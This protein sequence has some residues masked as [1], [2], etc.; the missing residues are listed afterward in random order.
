[1]CGAIVV[2]IQFASGDCFLFS[3][4]HNQYAFQPALYHARGNTV[5]FS[6]I[7]I[8][9]FLADLKAATKNAVIN[10]FKKTH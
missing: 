7:S 10:N 4:E 9:C 3:F 8:I 6:I 2:F 1:M 5:I